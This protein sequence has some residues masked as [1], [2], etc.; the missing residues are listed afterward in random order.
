MKKFIK[1]LS[2]ALILAFSC[3][4][5]TACGGPKNLAKAE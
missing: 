5:L 4:L 2:L 3:V 1:G